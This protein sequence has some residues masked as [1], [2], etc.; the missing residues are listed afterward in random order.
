MMEPDQEQAIAEV[1][2]LQGDVAISVSLSWCTLDDDA[3][4][5]LKRRAGWR[6]AEE[7]HAHLAV[8][9]FAQASAPLTLDADTF[10]SLFDEARPV[11]HAEQPGF[12]GGLVAE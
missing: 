6:Y 8:V 11:D 9:L 12:A 5:C 4:E 1:E 3:L 2:L 10:P 7:E